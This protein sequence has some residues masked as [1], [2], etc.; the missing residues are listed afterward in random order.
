MRQGCN[1][2]ARL[3]MTVIRTKLNTGVLQKSI[4]LKGAR[5]CVGDAVKCA[6]ILMG[7]L[8]SSLG[9]GFRLA[10]KGLNSVSDRKPYGSYPKFTAS[11]GSTAL[12]LQRY[13]EPY[14]GLIC[15]GPD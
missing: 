2:S 9:K 10:H 12:L 8:S 3:R 14:M 6:G 13:S 11:W 5:D 4:I 15:I 7:T 1:L